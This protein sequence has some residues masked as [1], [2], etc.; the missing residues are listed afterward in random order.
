MVGGMSMPSDNTDKL[1]LGTSPGHLF[2]KAAIPG[3]LGMLASSLYYLLE[4]ILVGR[5]LGA[6]PFAAINLAMPFVIINF[7]IS[8]MIGVGSSVPIAIK[9]GRGEK[10]EANSIFS[11][12]IVMIAVAGVITGS[13]LFISAPT[14]FHLMGAD[15]HLIPYA[16]DYLRMYACFSPLTTMVFAMDNY[17]RICG[18]IKGSLMMNICMASAGVVFEVFFL[19]IL[20]G[21]IASAALGTCCGM[22]SAV[23]VVLSIFLSGRMNLRFR[24]PQ[25]H[26]S[27]IKT[28][29]S[30][31]LPT[32]LSNVSGRIIS[33][34]MNVLLLSLGGASAVSVYGIIMSAD[35]VVMPLLYGT[36]DS[37]Q[38]SVGYNWGARRYDRVGKIERYCFSTGAI[39]SLLFGLFLFFFPDFAVSLFIEDNS[40][41]IHTLGITAL[42][43]SAFAFIFRWIAVCTQCFMSAIEKPFYAA[44]I[45]VSAAFVFPLILI[46]ALHPIGLNGIW[47]NLP[48][49]AFLTAMLALFI[50][51]RYRVILDKEKKLRSA[52]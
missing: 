48:G 23:L 14:L 12:A 2:F 17:L 13:L 45:S 8:D 36:C 26:L 15:E 25:F 9:L 32:F 3:A 40:T 21:G 31:G 28:I 51:T 37:L 41:G 29:V 10:E 43:I 20:K 1:F 33:I 42:K 22:S 30:C 35:G 49:T 46:I 39:I 34:I 19:I 44:S 47:M 24:K 27:L 5:V 4:G 7:A 18:K 16:V 38:P 52:D 6:E 11:A 50:L